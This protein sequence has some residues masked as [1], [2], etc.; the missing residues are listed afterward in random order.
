MR[1]LV[2]RSIVVVFLAASA[3]C[4]RYVETQEP[5]SSIGCPPTPR[6]FFRQTADSSTPGVIHG[7]VLIASLSD[8]SLAPLA[9][10]SVA[11]MELRRGVLADRDGAFRLGALA[12]GRYAVTVRSIG[13]HTYGDTVVVGPRA[14]RVIE[15]GLRPAPTDECPGFAVVIGRKRVWRW[16]WQ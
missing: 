3:G 15:V 4:Y 8:S 11:L 1:I 10:A 12:P 9:G 2:T 5:P 13:Y 6:A 16:P 14:G 7:R